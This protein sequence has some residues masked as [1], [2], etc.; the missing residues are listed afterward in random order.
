LELGKIFEITE[1]R[2]LVIL[3][4]SFV[5]SQEMFSEIYWKAINAQVVLRIGW[6][7][8][9]GPIYG[10]NTN[11]NNQVIEFVLTI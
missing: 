4:V 2:T 8:L 10:K 9:M 5:F 3:C 1:A 7:S 6:T 11:S